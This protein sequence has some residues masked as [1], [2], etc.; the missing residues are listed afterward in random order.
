M[1]VHCFLDTEESPMHL[2]F[3]CPFAMTC[4]NTL[5]FAHLIQNE[6]L[7]TISAFKD[8]FPSPFFHGGLHFNVLGSLDLKE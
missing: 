5:G 7:S 2:F 6:L 4:W 8:Y 3:H 1:C